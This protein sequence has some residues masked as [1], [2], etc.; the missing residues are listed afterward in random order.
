LKGHLPAR[1]PYQATHARQIPPAPLFDLRQ[2]DRA[3]QDLAACLVARERA[4]RRR[5]AVPKSALIEDYAQRVVARPAYAP[6]LARET[7]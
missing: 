6:A 4:P 2:H 5:P 3:H 7:A 1:E